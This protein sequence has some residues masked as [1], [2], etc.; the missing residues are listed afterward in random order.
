MQS[1][2]SLTLLDGTGA[3][4]LLIT[5]LLLSAAAQQLSL[6]QGVEPVLLKAIV[7]NSVKG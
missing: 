3:A 2:C 4:L 1:V 7:F 6:V 5:G